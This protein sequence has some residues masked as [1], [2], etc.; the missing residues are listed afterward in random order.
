[1]VVLGHGLSRY[2]VP[3][4]EGVGAG[5]LRDRGINGTSGADGD[6]LLVNIPNA[7]HRNSNN[8][9]YK[10]ET[11][12]MELNS[13]LK[14]FMQAPDAALEAMEDARRRVTSTVASEILMHSKARAPIELKL[15]QGP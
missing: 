9:L 3:D 4:T 10:L 12:V 2:M 8:T 1:M 11:A 7:C 6:A 14:R 13:E 15:E 5:T